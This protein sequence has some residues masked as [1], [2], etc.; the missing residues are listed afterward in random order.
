MKYYHFQIN[1]QK[2]FGV[3]PKPLKLEFRN[4]E[5]GP[6]KPL[7]WE[8]RNI[9]LGPVILGQENEDC[10][11]SKIKKPIQNLAKK[12]LGLRLKRSAKKSN[13][14]L[15]SKLRNF[16]TE[17]IECDTVM[18]RICPG[19]GIGCILCQF[20]SEGTCNNVCTVKSTICNAAIMRCL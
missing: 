13:S 18:N 17:N 3:L 14:T 16:M 2:H 4:I 12:Y 10:E 9:E 6:V 20:F 11:P 7:K 19:A 8:F 15:I 5:L 1:H